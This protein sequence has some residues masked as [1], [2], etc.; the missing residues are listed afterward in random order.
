MRQGE[1]FSATQSP[2]TLKRFRRLQRLAQL[3]D[4][5]FQIPGTRWRFGLD[6]LIG[7]VPGLGDAASAVISLWL[8]AEAKRLGAP[9]ASLRKMLR[10]VLVDSVAGSIPVLGDAFDAGYKA[11]L[12]NVALL[13]R[14]LFEPGRKETTG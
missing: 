4:S 12:R 1:I 13:E 3:L 10:N 14:A 2:E 6:P 11:N 9:S 7:L 8:I 5:E